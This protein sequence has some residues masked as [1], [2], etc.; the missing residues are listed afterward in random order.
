[1]EQRIILSIVA[2]IMVFWVINK[3]Q[4]D[5]ID[6]IFTAGLGAGIFLSWIGNEPFFSI[7]LTLYLLTTLVI[8]LHQLISKKNEKS[9]Q[10]SIFCVCIWTIISHLSNLLNWPFAYETHLS[11][12]FPLLFYTISIF[13]GIYKT[14]AFSYSMILVAG[15]I[16]ILW[17]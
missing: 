16:L 15:L 10:W 2:I 3:N 14:T 12:I 5:K 1:M 6:I 13:K 11:I 4:K 7:G 17:R 8:L 9:F